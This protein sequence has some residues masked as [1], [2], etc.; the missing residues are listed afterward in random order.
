MTS[1]RTVKLLAHQCVHPKLFWVLKVLPPV[2]QD[3]NTTVGKSRP[4]SLF[5]LICLNFLTVGSQKNL[6]L[7]THATSHQK[8]LT[9]HKMP[10]HHHPPSSSTHVQ[11]KNP[12]SSL[13]GASYSNCILSGISQK[14]IHHL[15]L[16][17]NR[18][19]SLL[20]VSEKTVLPVCL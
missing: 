2:C 14:S 15:K 12:P 6:L 16:V 20:T 3:R 8:D 19:E 11:I 7:L 13:P 17:A 10:T 4:R 1:A 5:W 18:A 9:E